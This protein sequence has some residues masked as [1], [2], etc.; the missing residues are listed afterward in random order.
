MKNKFGNSKAKAFLKTFEDLASLDS[1]EC[2]LSSRSKFNFS[3]FDKSQKH[4]G[5]ISDWSKEII[6]DFFEKLIDYSSKSLGQL[7][8]IGIGKRRHGLL[9]LYDSFPKNSGFVQP[10]SI[11]HQ[12]RWGRFRL[13][14]N[15]RLIGFV[16]PDEYHGLIHKGTGIV[17]D[18][19]T[20][21]IVFIDN[22]H[23]FYPLSGS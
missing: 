15:K 2:N 23:A 6:C 18:K 22:D 10:K 20:F 14:Q 11:P 19:N 16:I 5:Q 3:Y 8:Q 7:Q 4:S 17:Y 9:S 13:D 12:V 1:L 21:Y